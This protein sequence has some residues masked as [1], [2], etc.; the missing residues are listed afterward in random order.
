MESFY[1]RIKGRR[2]HGK[3]VFLD[4]SRGNSNQQIV[5]Q[6]SSFKKNYEKAKRELQI[7]NIVRIEGEYFI[8]SS[9]VKTLNVRT[10]AI[11]TY[12][13]DADPLKS[14]IKSE[15]RRRNRGLDILTSNES[16]SRYTNIV[17]IN[18]A[19]RLYLYER[20]FLEVETGILKETTDT[21]KA[22]DF[23]TKAN[24]NNQRLYLRKSTEQRLKQLL[25]G[26]L[27]NI[28][29]MGKVFRNESVGRDF[30]PE[31]TALELYQSYATYREML[32]IVK[33][34]L[35]RLNEVV[36]KP[37]SNPSDFEEVM[38]YD[39]LSERTG[40]D[41]ISTDT[42]KLV[43]ITP[44]H[45]RKTYPDKIGR[46]GYILND[47][48]ESVIKETR[49]KNLTITGY[50]KEINI[51][52]R[53]MESDSTLS[54]EFR[55]Y[56]RGRSYCYGC[57]ELTDYFE[58]ERRIKAQADFLGKPIDNL[59][60]SFIK[61]LKIGLPPCAGLGLSLE[62]LQMIYLNLEDVRDAITFPL[63]R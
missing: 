63:Q 5:I 3:V 32:E 17:K 50:P 11:L 41:V 18:K 23:T 61:M 10:Y 14:E 25:A 28:F 1:G 48:F 15:E 47:L 34:I 58:Q 22:D 38:F 42:E 43:S 30:S 8:S 40:I 33:G 53:E 59:D 52:S 7:G 26:G 51:L 46:R 60:P 35:S 27:E 4:V 54:E 36:G 20:G 45:K 24:W 16:F 19:I 21:S 49:D 55:M 39:F 9:D 37:K 12:C 31:F 6:K 62:R 2:D 29:E 56:V 57:T 44:Q 13:Y